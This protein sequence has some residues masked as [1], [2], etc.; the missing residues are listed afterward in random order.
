[1]ILSAFLKTERHVSVED[2]YRILKKSKKRIGYATVYRTMKL[3]ADCGLARGV[4]FDDG[5]LRF[6]HDYKHEHHHHLVCTRC[7]KVIEFTSKKMDRELEVV[8][9]KYNFKMESHSFKIFGI[10]NKC[11]EEI[12]C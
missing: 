8:L 5:I 10:C 2:L 11:R 4:E 6:E 7:K 9:K 3:I 1:L 12:G